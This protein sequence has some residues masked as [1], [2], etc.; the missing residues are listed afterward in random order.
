MIPS[1]YS[2][3][4]LEPPQQIHAPDTGYVPVPL[5]MLS[6]NENLQTKSLFPKPV[7]RP[8]PFPRQH[9]QPRRGPPQSRPSPRVPEWRNCGGLEK[10]ASGAP[11]LCASAGGEVGMG[12]RSPVE[13]ASSAL[14]FCE[15]GERASC[16]A[17][18]KRTRS[19]RLNPGENTRTRGAGR[20]RRCP[21]GGRSAQPEPTR[22]PAPAHCRGAAGGPGPGP[23]AGPGAGPF[24]PEHLRVGGLLLR[25][26]LPP[27]RR[28]GVEAGDDMALLRLPRRS[29]LRGGGEKNAGCGRSASGR[30]PSPQRRVSSPLP[31]HAGRGAAGKRGAAPGALTHLCDPQ[32]PREIPRQ[33]SRVRARSRAFWPMGRRDGSG[34]AQRMQKG[35]LRNGE[36]KEKGGEPSAP[37]R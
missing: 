9:G 12:C 32:Q 16:A 19:R 36:G 20:G 3:D 33:A 24:P 4:N 30:V 22:P 29:H 15:G 21:G 27:R 7:F 18:H 1:T 11:G 31:A 34:R 28:L 14:R 26:R 10:R 2:H 35:G 17:R 5:A 37:L 6:A 25:P 8:D 13:A 23:G